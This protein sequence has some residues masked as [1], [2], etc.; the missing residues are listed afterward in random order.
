[1]DPEY[2]L[3]YK[4][5]NCGIA[6]PAST[7]TDWFV[8]SN[9]RVYVNTRGAFSYENWIAGMK[10]GNTFITNG[11]ALDLRVNDQPMGAA[12]AL[13]NGG[14][15]DIESTF[16]SF[17]P[18]HCAEIAMNGAVIHRET[19]PEGKREGTIRHGVRVD[20]DGWVAARLWGNQRDSFDQ[21]IYAHSSPVYFVCGRPPAER[22]ASAQ[23]FLNRIEDALDWIDTYGR[24]NTDQQREEVKELFRKGREVYAGLIS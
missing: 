19:Y 15:L 13:P 6:L 2:D 7:G 18:I 11:P 1:M 23:Y 21:S 20:R 14:S 3:W 8:C 24:Y 12:V 9:N 17:Y 5:L 10:S 16:A 22:D 4:L